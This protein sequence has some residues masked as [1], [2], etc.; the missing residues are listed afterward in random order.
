MEVSMKGSSSKGWFYGLALLG[1][2]GAGCE[3]EDA[4]LKVRRVTPIY[5]EDRELV[6]FDSQASA[7]EEPVVLGEVIVRSGGSISKY[8]HWKKFASQGANVPAT[9]AC[10][11]WGYPVPKIHPGQK[12]KICK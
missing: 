12:I 6:N 10:N 2:I 9:V 1:L 3:A 11:D 4:E 7:G 8:V 5:L